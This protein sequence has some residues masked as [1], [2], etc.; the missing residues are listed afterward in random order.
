MT[1]MLRLIFALT[2]GFLAAE[3]RAITSG[4]QVTEQTIRAAMK[5]APLTSQQ[6]GGVQRC[7]AIA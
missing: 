6:A 4:S 1:T 5:D 7:P 3:S 2:L